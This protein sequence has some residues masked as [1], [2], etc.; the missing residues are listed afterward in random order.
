MSND[1]SKFAM[2]LTL[3][4]ATTAIGSAVLSVSLV[5]CSEQ[6]FR[7]KTQGP[8]ATVNFGN[9]DVVDMNAPTVWKAPAATTP[10]P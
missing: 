1:K 2:V 5:S 3:A 4:T 6:A 8:V 7:A 9:P 10:K